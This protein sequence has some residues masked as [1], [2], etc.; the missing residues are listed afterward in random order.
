MRRKRVGFIAACIICSVVAVLHAQDSDVDLVDQVSIEDLDSLFS[1]AVDTVVE[2]EDHTEVGE[3]VSK[4]LEGIVSFPLK[5]SGSFTGQLGAAYWPTDD[6]HSGYMNF[7]NHLYFN[8]RPVTELTLSADLRTTYY[9]RFGFELYQI[10]YD[11]IMFS[12]MFL[13]GGKKSLSWGEPHLYSSSGN[14]LNDSVYCANIGATFPFGPISFKGVAL[15]PIHEIDAE[16]TSTKDTD[17]QTTED[18]TGSKISYAGA[19]EFVWHSMSLT[20]YYRRWP[21]NW[22]YKPSGAVYHY[23]QAFGAQAKQSIFDHI[24][25]YAQGFVYTYPEKYRI[26]KEYTD[27]Q[28]TQVIAGMYGVWDTPKFGFSLEYM[29]YR[30]YDEKFYKGVDV[31]HE[32]K[33]AYSVGLGNLVDGHLAL[34]CTGNHNFTL[35]QGCVTPGFVIKRVFPS[36]DLQSGVQ[37][38]YNGYDRSKEGEVATCVA[39]KLVF[40]IDY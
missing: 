27:F 13:S 2:P 18:T 5:F 38:Q 35:D 9:N 23:D 30:N 28:Q 14:I 3:A 16:D 25:V 11:Y 26:D 33:V 7:E 19:V 1:G 36:A 22:Q 17:Q 37:V 8:A 12:H 39:L 31:G 20:A 34:V 10:Y 4:S 15:T 40:S 32:H 29:Y 21:T 6:S 24:D